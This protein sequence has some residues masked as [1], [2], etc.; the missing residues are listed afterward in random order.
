MIAV[1]N[2]RK[3]AARKDRIILL[4]ATRRVMKG[5]PKNY[6]P[7]DVIRPLAAAYLKG[8]PIEGEIAV[9]TRQQAEDADYNLSQA[10]TSATR[11]RLRRPHYRTSS[12]SYLI[13]MKRLPL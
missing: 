6:V 3:P 2:K 10:G 7:G 9:I 11:M 13:S 12:R 4:N 5:K 8:E 1:L